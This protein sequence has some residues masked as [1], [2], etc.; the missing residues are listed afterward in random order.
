[1]LELGKNG[2]H[3]VE[4]GVVPVLENGVVVATLRAPNWKE[5]A[6]AEVQAR[7]WVFR[8]ASNRELT[9]RMAA[10]P[11]DAVRLRARQESYLRDTWTVELEGLPVEV[12]TVSRWKGT[13]R[14]SA[15]GRPL[16]ESGTTGGWSPQPT[17]TV[18]PG[19]SLDSAV[20]LLWIE[21]VLSRRAMAVAAT[22]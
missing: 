21:L 12:S 10:D 16:A 11:D 18:Q 22:V 17:L 19:L 9:G 4:K 5:A 7:S 20:F 15:Q 2:S 3:G 14:Y 6:T 1:V 13:H 8:R